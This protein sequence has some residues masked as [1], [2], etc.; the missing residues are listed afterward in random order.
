[1]FRIYPVEVAA[2]LETG[3]RLLTGEYTPPDT[4][5]LDSA[6]SVFTFST[7][8]VGNH[9]ELVANLIHTASSSGNFMGVSQVYLTQQP[10]LSSSRMTP[11]TRLLWQR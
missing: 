9:R 11:T 2:E 10:G 6:C 4:T 3:S 1:M 5:Q 7:K 8:S